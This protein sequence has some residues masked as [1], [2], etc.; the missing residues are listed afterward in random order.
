MLRGLTSAIFKRTLFDGN[1]AVK[2]GGAVA[3]YVDPPVG[4]VEFW[5][6]TFKNNRVVDLDAVSSGGAIHVSSVSRFLIDGS[7]FTGNVAQYGGAI[8]II[9]NVTQSADSPYVIRHSLFEQNGGDQNA[10]LISEPNRGGAIWIT[11]Y[12]D[13]IGSWTTQF[14]NT[15][16]DFGKKEKDYIFLN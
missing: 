14:K 3:V 6:C 1:E 2:P 7:T 10:T 11:D 5:S 9:P 13:K 16:N 15:N 12:P 4:R 8:Q